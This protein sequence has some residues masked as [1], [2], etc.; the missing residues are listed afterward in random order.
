MLAIR[1]DPRLFGYELVT[2]FILLGVGWVGPLGLAPPAQLP[3]VAVRRV[4]VN[5]QRHPVTLRWDSRCSS[6]KAKLAA[7]GRAQGAGK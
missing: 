5:P 6:L 4:G 7:G 1:L 3:S 2:L